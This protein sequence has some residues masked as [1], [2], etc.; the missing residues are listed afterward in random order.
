MQ[1]KMKVGLIP[2]ELHIID[3][4]LQ[5]LPLNYPIVILYKQYIT[6][7]NSCKCKKIS[8]INVRAFSICEEGCVY[9]V[10][11]II[12]AGEIRGHEFFRLIGILI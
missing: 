3:N 2:L 10:G 12:G 5:L 6:K 1:D 8:N 9:A 4:S 7:N 11:G